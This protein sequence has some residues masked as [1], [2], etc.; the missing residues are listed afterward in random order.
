M[1]KW[2]LER[3]ELLAR[4]GSGRVGGLSHVSD[5]VFKLINDAVA[6]EQRRR[7]RTMTETQD[8]P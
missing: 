5:I 6:I 1:S 2:A 4:D 8:L 3:L 7:Y